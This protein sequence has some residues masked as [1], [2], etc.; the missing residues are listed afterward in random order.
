VQ[1]FRFCRFLGVITAICVQPMVASAA[2]VSLQSLQGQLPVKSWQELRDERVVKQDRD[3]S[4]GAASLATILQFQYGKMITEG[5]VLKAFNKQDAAS[6]ADMANALP[7]FGFKGIGAALDYAQLSKLK[8]PVVL[9]LRYRGNDHFSVLRGMDDERVW[10]AD[11]SWGNKVL[12]RTEF[13]SMWY[14]RENERLPGKALLVLQQRSASSS[15]NK[16]FFGSP[17]RK[18]PPS[19]L[20]FRGS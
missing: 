3:Y 17:P 7:I 14:T 10:L 12:S 11:P 2:S 19:H 9:Y 20:T 6:F 13:L 5:D 16:D 4:C 8:I 1:V 18:M 15:V